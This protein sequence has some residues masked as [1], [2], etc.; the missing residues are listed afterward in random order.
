MECKYNVEDLNLLKNKD[1][2]LTVL[3]YVGIENGYHYFICNCICGKETKVQYNCI[4]N[5]GVLSCGCLQIERRAG[6]CFKYPVR[7]LEL[8]SRY[9]SML[10]RC[11]NKN[12][13]SYK[14]YGAK[15]V[16]VCEEWR[17]DY[18]EFLNWSLNNGWQ[19]GLLIDKDI[20]V[21]G[22]K[23]YGPDTC[24]WVTAKENNRN[25]SISVKYDHNGTMKTLGDICE[26]IGVPYNRMHEHVASKGLEKAI[27]Y[28]KTHPKKYKR[29]W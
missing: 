9:R 24:S 6:K 12:Q 27:E 1:S 20:K 13:S 25:R 26:E 5:G 14:Q 21:P 22:N 10:H 17:N 8:E 19:P 18:V 15:G 23:I 4:I 3:S 7:I 2:R 28:F 16:S 29:N 11:Y